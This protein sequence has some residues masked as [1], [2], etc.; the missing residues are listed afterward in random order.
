MIKIG[1][2]SVGNGHECFIV[3]EAGPTHSG[4]ESAKK[5]AYLARNAGGQA[6]K[7]QILDTDKLILDKSQLFTYKILKTNYQVN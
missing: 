6:I 1:K 2:F 4:L 7:F 3:F 5:L